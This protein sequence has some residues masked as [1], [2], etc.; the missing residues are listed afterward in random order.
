MQPIGEI[1]V[2]S[3]VVSCGASAT[4]YEAC[5]AMHE[6]K[7]GAVLVLSEEGVALG[8][9]TERDLLSR[10][11]IPSLDPKDVPVGTVMTRGVFTVTPTEK[12]S[13][14]RREMTRRH[15]RHV[16]VVD[17]GEIKG[18]LSLRDLLKADLSEQKR[19]VEA[20]TTY[21]QGGFEPPEDLREG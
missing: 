17:G 13:D 1:L 19:E 5:K 7:I 8:I 12:A 11:V 2:N 9:F 16:P 3:Q 4:V 14:V 18:I 15:I 20:I 6:A 21:I 10:V